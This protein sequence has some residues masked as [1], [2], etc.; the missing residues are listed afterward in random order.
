MTFKYRRSGRKFYERLPQGDET[1][2]R[3]DL[4]TQELFFPYNW[5]RYFWA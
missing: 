2:L 3:I 4:A 1:D 5:A